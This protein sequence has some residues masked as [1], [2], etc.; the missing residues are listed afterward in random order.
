M[1]MYGYLQIR[2]LGRSKKG[3]SLCLFPE[4]KRDAFSALRQR[5]QSDHLLWN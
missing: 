5:H 4:L 1:I 3:S 2:T